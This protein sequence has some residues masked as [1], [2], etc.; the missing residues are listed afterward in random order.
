M[1]N[2][3]GDIIMNVEI[4]NAEMTFSKEDGF[5]GKVSFRYEN[6][7]QPYEIH[8]QKLNGKDWGYSLLF[9]EESGTEENILE[10]EEVLE[11]TDELFDMLV[12]TAKKTVIK[13]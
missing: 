8:L 5:V 9:L 3:K 13:E 11:D 6:H 7:D 2:Y 12:E 10:L 4:L 1:Q